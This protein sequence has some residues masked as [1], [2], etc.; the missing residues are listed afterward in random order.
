MNE[1]DRPANLAESKCVSLQ[2]K[3]AG[4][5]GS[6]KNVDTLTIA[7]ISINFIL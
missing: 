2:E 5:C 4:E 6:F 1:S 3:N 7:L